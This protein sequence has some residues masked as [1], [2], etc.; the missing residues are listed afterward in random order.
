MPYSAH[1]GHPTVAFVVVSFF[2]DKPHF[3]QENIT[4]KFFST[5]R[6]KKLKEESL[7]LSFTVCPI[8]RNAAELI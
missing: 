4:H 8:S 3:T 1:S 2:R 6:Q 7:F 5:N